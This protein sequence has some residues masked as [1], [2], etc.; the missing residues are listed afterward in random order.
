MNNV[1]KILKLTENCPWFG[2]SILHPDGELQFLTQS[3]KKII[4][5]AP[6]SFKRA[7][8]RQEKP[9][10]S[11]TLVFAVQYFAPHISFVNANDL[12]IYSASLRDKLFYPPVLNSASIPEL[13][14]SIELAALCM[15]M[16]KSNTPE[17]LHVTPGVKFTEELENLIFSSYKTLKIQEMSFT[18]AQM[19]FS[20]LCMDKIEGLQSHIYRDTKTNDLLSISYSGLGIHTSEGTIKYEF[21]WDK[22]SKLVVNKSVSDN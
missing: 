3:E 5:F 13:E 7:I 2:L 14:T 11:F 18:R 6:E 4:R 9:N 21:T 19:L 16:D 22:I 17:G 8:E 1:L 15:R 20:K 12:T 10:T